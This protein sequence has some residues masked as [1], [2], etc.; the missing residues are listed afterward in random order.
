MLEMSNVGLPQSSSLMHS[1]DLFYLWE[2]SN[3]SRIL[4][5]IWG[6]RHGLPKLHVGS[7]CYFF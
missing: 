1:C 6:K 5:I 4:E 2:L 3:I 7:D